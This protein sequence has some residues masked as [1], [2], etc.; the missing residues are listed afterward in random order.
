MA[1]LKFRD[2]NNE[3]IPVAV[4]TDISAFNNDVGYL[5]LETLPR[6]NGGVQ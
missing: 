4:P 6:Y 5:T 2:E 1:T 3:F